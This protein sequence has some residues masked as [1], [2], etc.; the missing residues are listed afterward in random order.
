MCS[1]AVARAAARACGAATAQLL[2]L[3]SQLPTLLAYC[4]SDQLLAD[5]PAGERKQQPSMPAVAAAMAGLHLL[6]CMD[7]SLV[8]FAKGGAAPAAAGAE[9][10]VFLLQDALEQQLLLSSGARP[11]SG[12]PC[13]KMQRLAAWGLAPFHGQ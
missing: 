9:R 2:A 5:G 7:G 3:G 13:L 11:A 4:L 12:L 1:P 6:P 10:T 8:A